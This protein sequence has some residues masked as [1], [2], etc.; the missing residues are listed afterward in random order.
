MIHSSILNS[1]LLLLIILFLTAILVIASELLYSGK[2]VQYSYSRDYTLKTGKALGNS[3]TKYGIVI[4]DSRGKCGINT[5]FLKPS[6]NDFLYLNLCE[7]GALANLLLKELTEVNNLPEI[8]I[9]AVSPADIFGFV[10]SNYYKPVNSFNI[11]KY[12]T[13][14][15]SLR[16]PYS[17][18][19][20]KIT[21]YLKMHYRFVLG[22]N[23]FT[24]LVFF[25]E[26]SKYTTSSGW[27][28][29]VRLGSYKNY[30]E[31]TNIHFYQDLLLENYKYSGFI[32]KLKNELES[33]IEKVTKKNSKIVLVRIPTSDKIKG[34]ENEKFPWFN[35]YFNSL[36][37]K[38]NITYLTFDN[39]RY[40]ENLS[41]GSHLTYNE[42]NKFSRALSDSL[43][44]I[45]N[46]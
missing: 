10:D 18:S 37:N 42:A 27:T 4:G 32:D 2:N 33:T 23:E 17:V 39:F 25:G 44:F 12:L 30:S 11:Q 28:S 15:L 7:D 13:F 38:Y 26:I 8:I 21:E 31:L 29:N 6:G 35:D 14:P 24:N 16:N 45:L 20:T 46:K 22:F 9:M 41:D 1:K 34:I 5:D 3:Q 19:E 40:N 36:E 43:T